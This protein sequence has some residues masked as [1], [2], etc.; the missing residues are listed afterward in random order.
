MT[1]LYVLKY[2]SFIFSVMF[3]HS[4]YFFWFFSLLC[5]FLQIYHCHLTKFTHISHVER[6]QNVMKTNCRH[7]WHQTG[8]HSVMT[9]YAKNPDPDQSRV[10]MN[11]IRLR[12]N[13]T[14]EGCNSFEIDSELY[15]VSVLRFIYT[16]IR[17]HIY[18]Y[19]RYRS[20]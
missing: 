11:S 10:E 14:F 2:C 7:D 6:F 19:I 4:E 5:N 1:S 12:L 13:I 15:D 8:Q 3:F 17:N 16:K 20:G 18:S 9:I